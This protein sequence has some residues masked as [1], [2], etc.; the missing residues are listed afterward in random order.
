MNE[1][2]QFIRSFKVE[3]SFWYT[4]IVDIAF[5]AVIA[6]L[7]QSFGRF[8]QQKLSQLGGMD[9]TEIQNIIMSMNPDQIQGYVNQLKWFVFAFIAGWVVIML[10]TVLVSSLSRTIIWNRILDRKFSLKRYWRWNLYIL[11]FAAMLILYFAAFLAV[12]LGLTFLISYFNNAY[13]VQ[14]FSQL[15][16]LLGFAILLVF[17]L[18]ANYSFARKYKVFASLA[19]TFATIRKRWSQ[20]WKAFVFSYLV[21]VVMGLLIALAQFYLFQSSRNGAFFSIGL[22]LLYISWLRLYLFKAVHHGH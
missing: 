21:L 18:L 16:N 19:D 7:F 8:V 3:D 14:L 22:L 11:L 4:L 13:L 1:I 15:V 10:V 17:L 12:K 2:K 5:F 20:L 9:P 6:F